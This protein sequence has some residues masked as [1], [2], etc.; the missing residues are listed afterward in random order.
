VYGGSNC[1]LSCKDPWD[2]VQT[3]TAVC[4]DGNVN[5]STP[6]E[7]VMPSCHKTCVEPLDGAA[8]GRRAGLGGLWPVPEP[9]RRRWGIMNGIKL[10]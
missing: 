3:T 6:L 2:T 7:W 10:S 4:P 8:Q 5:E 9:E 1:T